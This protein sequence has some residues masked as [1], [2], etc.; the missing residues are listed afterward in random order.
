MILVQEAHPIILLMSFYSFLA[1][2]PRH[3]LKSASYPNVLCIFT[4]IICSQFSTI[5]TGI[6]MSNI[7]TILGT[8]RHSWIYFV[9]FF[10]NT[11]LYLV[12]LIKWCL[13]TS[14]VQPTSWYK[15]LELVITNLDWFILNQVHGWRTAT[16]FGRKVKLSDH[17]ILKLVLKSL[18]MVRV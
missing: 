16:K 11:T 10:P 14:K 2:L 5:I 18:K 3:I 4:V 8:I 7:S 6:T 1:L 17:A 15:H 13:E 12:D 9:P